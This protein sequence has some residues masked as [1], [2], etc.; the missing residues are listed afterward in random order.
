M[1]G[2]AGLTYKGRQELVERCEAGTPP[3]TVARLMNVSRPTVYK[4]WGR[5]QADP[6][7]AWWLDKPSRPCH[8]CPT[9]TRRRV[10][11]KI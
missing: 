11:R 6:A 5:D 9:Q 4:W 8:R 10:E 1:H 3:A 7:G 2:N